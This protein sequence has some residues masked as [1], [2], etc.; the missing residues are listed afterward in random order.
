MKSQRAFSERLL[1]NRLKK[2]KSKFYGLIKL[3]E[4]KAK[5]P[6]PLNP[7]LIV[8]K[9]IEN[10][11]N[12]TAFEGLKLVHKLNN[13]FYKKRINIDESLKESQEFLDGF[14]YFK[15]AQDKNILKKI[16]KRRIMLNSILKSY[17]DKGIFFQEDFI[18]KN[19]YNKSGMLLRKKKLIEDYYTNQVK[20]GRENNKKI[21]KYENF[22]NKL[23]KETKKILL[24]KSPC[25]DPQLLK[26]LEEN[27]EDNKNDF[28][29]ILNLKSKEIIDKLINENNLL[30]NLI[31]LDKK[32]FENRMNKIE[33]ENKK[34]NDIVNCIKILFK[35]FMF[36][37]QISLYFI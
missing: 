20:Q 23:L 28:E 35:I 27:K 5:K 15:S 16:E 11:E 13:N 19:I 2:N 7:K 12:K 31:E 33:Q 29:N 9:K 26:E 1:M 10:S 32:N 30:K 17:E 14:N 36:N 6:I 8:N 21:I 37:I 4:I 34:D 24:L 22:L 3:L 18:N 25:K